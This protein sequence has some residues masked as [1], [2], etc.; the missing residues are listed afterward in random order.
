MRDRV[1]VHEETEFTF[2]D[3][4]KGWFDIRSQPVR[5]GIFV[6]SIDI[7]ERRSAR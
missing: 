4:T 6:L 2:A 7:S 5:E 1:R 3:G